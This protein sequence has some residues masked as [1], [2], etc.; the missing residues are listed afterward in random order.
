LVRVSFEEARELKYT[1][2]NK[3]ICINYIYD[4]FS[5]QLG[6]LATLY[7]STSYGTATVVAMFGTPSTCFQKWLLVHLASCS[8]WRP[9]RS[10]AGQTRAYPLLSKLSLLTVAC[11]LLKEHFTQRHSNCLQ[12]WF[13]DFL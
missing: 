11:G 3:C 4:L 13:P 1:A 10:K 12:D 7:Y 6:A 5:E 2:P 8:P 9:A